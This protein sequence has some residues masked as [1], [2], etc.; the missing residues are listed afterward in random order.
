MPRSLRWRLALTSGLIT[1]GSAFVLGLLLV[2]ELRIYLALRQGVDPASLPPSDLSFLD[3][4]YLLALVGSVLLGLVATALTL[5]LS[6]L[7]AGSLQKLTDFTRR[8][9]EG[10]LNQY[11]H[12]SD[13]CEVEELA[14]ALGHTARRLRETVSNL[15][16]ERDTM[17]AMLDSLDD[18]IIIVSREGEVE[19]M[20]PA[21]R[22]ML[23]V[24]ETRALG[25][26][27]MSIV[28]SHEL[29]TLWTRAL[30]DRQQQNAEV[31]V[32]PSRRLLRAVAIPLSLDRGTVGLMVLH[33]LT[34]VRRADQ[35][36]REFVSNV[37][38]ELRTPLASLKL[39][40]ET[41][42][43]GAIE[44]EAAARGFLERMNVEVDGM[45]QLVH[46]L[47]ELSRI[48]SGRVSLKMEPVP[49]AALLEGAA[50]RL[51]SQAERAGLSLEVQLPAE[52]LIVRA[53]VD[54]IGQV[55]LNLIHN[56]IKFTPAGG[57]ITVAAERYESRV[58]IRV[59]DT[60]VGIPPEDLTRIFERFYKT[61]KARSSGGT[62]LGLAISKHLVQAHGGRIWAEN[63]VGQRGA[64]FT[65]TLPAAVEA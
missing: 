61:D 6:A 4:V 36:R 28:R 45:T 24:P 16:S 31:E 18:G 21:A 43:E 49:V 60:G 42:Q 5:P 25:Q 41:L 46:E 29:Q 20:N 7:T 59:A 17:E 57:A 50:A 53:D 35:V 39:L 12:L 1:A 55:L 38:H 9:A 26:S 54:R 56:A 8:M 34:D 63:R 52:A 62:G 2:Q 58:A 47:L 15:S 27:F 22:R 3:H 30:E 44:D 65:F 14:E 32:G 48:E 33:D 10:E 40:V 23:G 51:R 64:V 13:C 19:L 37:S 11:I